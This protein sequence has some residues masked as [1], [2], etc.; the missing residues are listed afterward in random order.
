VIDTSQPATDSIE[1]VATD[2]VGLT[3]TSTRTIV[4]EPATSATTTRSANACYASKILRRVFF[5]PI[6]KMLFE[7][8]GSAYPTLG[9]QPRHH[10]GFF[11]FNQCICVF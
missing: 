8:S 6:S 5:H 7:L 9:S 1:Y 4:I 2:S 3:A 11:P 10:R